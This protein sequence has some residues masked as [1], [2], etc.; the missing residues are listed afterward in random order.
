[1]TAGVKCVTLQSSL[2]RQIRTSLYV[3]KDEGG[4]KPPKRDGDTAA[5]SDITDVGR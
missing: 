4:K 5:G 1:M 3:G 2:S